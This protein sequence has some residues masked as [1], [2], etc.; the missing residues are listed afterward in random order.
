MQFVPYLN[1]DG[2]AA[3]A[4]AFY[5]ELF[6]GRIVYQ[7]TFGEMPPHEGMP[8]LP[9]AAKG[10]LMH[11][12]LQVGAQSI[13]ASDTMPAMPGQADEACA[14]G[15]RKPQG[16]W[17]AIQVDGTA[18]GRRVFDA[19]ARGG[20]VAMPFQATF[21]SAGFGMVTDRFGTPWMVNVASE[22]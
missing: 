22:T 1:F 8:P 20:Q 3:E 19:L 16:M 17:V 6:G 13:M 9:E 5:A 18:E 7:S 4:M 15:Y 14:G 21:W 2:D 11:A 10:R 12:H